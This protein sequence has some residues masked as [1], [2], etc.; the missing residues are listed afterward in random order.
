MCED[1]AT[2]KP[3]GAGWWFL[4]FAKSPEDRVS[5]VSL[6]VITAYL[7][8]LGGGWTGEAHCIWY[9]RRD[10]K[11]KDFQ[12]KLNGKI[13]ESRIPEITKRKLPHSNFI[14]DCDITSLSPI[15]ATLLGQTSQYLVVR[16]VWCFI[17]ERE[18]ECNISLLVRSKNNVVQ[19]PAS[20]L[21]IVDGVKDLEGGQKPSEDSKG[22]TY[23]CLDRFE[24]DWDIVG[25]CNSTT[26]NE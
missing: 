11:E 8:L 1:L 21:G 14:G 16:V 5:T 19:L 20:K 2:E 10:H 18:R 25:V 17:I 24:R 7:Y 4:G 13:R 23:L 3:I 15:H 26:M 12:S 22:V 9:Y 6:G